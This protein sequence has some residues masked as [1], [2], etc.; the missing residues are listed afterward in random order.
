MNAAIPLAIREVWKSYGRR[1]V[2]R[3]ISATFEGGRI[4]VLVGPNGAGKTTLMRIIAGLQYPDSGSIPSTAALY[5]GGFDTLPLKGRARDLRTA[6]GIEG[7]SR[8]D[9]RRLSRLSRGE[10]QWVGLEAALAL[11]RPATLL[12]EPWTSLEPDVREELNGWLRERASAGRVVICSTH[13]L[14]EASRLADD[15]LFLRDG[16]GLWIRREDRPGGV[17]E[18]DGILALFRR[19]EAKP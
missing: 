17:F 7:P 13:E 15:I 11:D 12:D 19:A 2:L 14:D 6:L 18:R 10:L 16:Q 3:G 8:F 4:A 1:P 9:D 5:Y